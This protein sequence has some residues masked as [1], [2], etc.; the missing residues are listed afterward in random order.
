MVTPVAPDADA[1]ATQTE[2]EA[3]RQNLLRG[4]D[5]VVRA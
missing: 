4:A 2:L 3:Q 1:V 5:E